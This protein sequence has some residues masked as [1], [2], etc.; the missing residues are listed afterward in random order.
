MSVGQQVS[1]GRKEEE[2]RCHSQNQ[3]KV[4]RRQG[5]K[6]DNGATHDRCNR[7]RDKKYEVFPAG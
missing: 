1:G 3:R 7:I 5:R 4:M 6:N 2:S